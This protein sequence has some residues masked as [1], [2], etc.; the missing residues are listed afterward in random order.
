[1]ICLWNE[2]QTVF[3]FS[4]V[5]I[6]ESGML[7]E[8]PINLFNFWHLPG[9]IHSRTFFRSCVHIVFSLLSELV[10]HIINFTLDSILGSIIVSV[11]L[12]AVEFLPSFCL[13]SYQH[14][15]FW[16]ENTSF[17]ILRHHVNE[18]THR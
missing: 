2:L 10:T 5:S 11:Q 9:Q 17:T 16:F 6:E 15:I 18:V 4:F 14:G 13:S 12:K 1:M 7:I 3:P 8:I